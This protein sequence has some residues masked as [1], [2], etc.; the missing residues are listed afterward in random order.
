MCDLLEEKASSSAASHVKKF[1][2]YFENN[3]VGV[4]TSRDNNRS[5]LK[6]QGKGN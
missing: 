5:S 6:V 2:H 1:L 4:K 3:H